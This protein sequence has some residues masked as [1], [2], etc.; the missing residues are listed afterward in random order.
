MGIYLIDLEILQGMCSLLE[1]STKEE[2]RKGNIRDGK[3]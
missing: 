1:M 2:K 3:I